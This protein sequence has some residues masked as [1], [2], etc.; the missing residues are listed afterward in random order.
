M[1]IINILGAE[2]V[3]V[4]ET[5]P[6]VDKPDQNQP[7]IQDGMHTYVIMIVML[8]VDRQCIILFTLFA[9]KFVLF[10]HLC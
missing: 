1:D 10:R 6:E 9:D 4:V 2:D 8:D 5:R 7:V 3:M